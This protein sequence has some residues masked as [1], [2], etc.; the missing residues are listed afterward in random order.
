MT[1]NQKYINKSINLALFNNV[2]PSK[3]LGSVLRHIYDYKN[4]NY[5]MH[6]QPLNF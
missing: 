2:L 3:F 4:Y 5:Y 6:L 1:P